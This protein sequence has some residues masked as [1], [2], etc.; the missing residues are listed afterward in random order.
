MEY[1]VIPADMWYLTYKAGVKVSVFDGEWESLPNFDKLKSSETLVFDQIEYESDDSDSMGVVANGYV[2]LREAEEL[3]FILISDDGSKLWLDDELLI[4][5]DGIMTEA[6]GKVGKAQLAAGM[7]KVRVDY[8]AQS[9]SSYIKL[10]VG[11]QDGF[12][13]G[14]W[15]H[16]YKDQKKRI[17]MVVVDPCEGKDLHARLVESNDRVNQE[18]D[19]NWI[20]DNC[21]DP[22]RIDE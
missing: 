3:E 11:N 15:W 21:F 4:D 9:G 20:I 22:S 13:Y 14:E 19:S 16:Y 12:D 2:L 7:H 5:N 10:L 18:V 17:E 6:L 1:Q 8:F